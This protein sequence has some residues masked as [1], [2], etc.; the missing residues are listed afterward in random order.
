MICA[1][2]KGSF[3]SSLGVP[4]EN[5]T[6]LPMLPALLPGEVGFASFGGLEVGVRV[7]PNVGVDA[8]NVKGPFEGVEPFPKVKPEPEGADGNEKGFEVFCSSACC[9]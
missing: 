6:E 9:G 2:A 8:P 4:K 5:P 7:A 1:A 3:F